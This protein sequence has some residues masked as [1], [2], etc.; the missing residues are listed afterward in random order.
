MIPLVR[1]TWLRLAYRQPS[2]L[3]SKSVWPRQRPLQKQQQQCR[4]CYHR[5]QQ[6][7]D[8]RITTRRRQG[9]PQRIFTTVVLSRDDC[10]H[11]WHR[12]WKRSLTSSTTTK[13]TPTAGDPN[14]KGR[15]R[16][17]ILKQ[18]DYLDQIPLQDVR[19]FCFIAHI[20]HGKSSLSSRILELTGNLGED[21]QTLAWDIIEGRTV[22]T[23]GQKERIEIL[24]TLAVEQQRGITV[25]ASCA[26]MLYP[27]PSAVGPTG[28][29]LVN[30]FDLPGHVD[31][32]Q[33]VSRSLH[34]VQGAVLLLDSAQGIQAQTWSAYDK[35]RNMRHPPQLLVALTKVDLETARPVHVALTVSEWL[36]WDDPDRIIWTS[37]RNRI[38][39]KDLLDAVCSQVP[40]PKPLEDDVSLEQDVANGIL[41]AVVVD[42]WY[43]PGGVH[44]LIQVLSG[45]LREGDRIA[46]VSAGG[47]SDGSGTTTQATPANATSKGA[48]TFVLVQQIGLSLPRFHRTSYLKRGQIGSVLLGLR[49]PRQ[50][51][52]GTVLVLST[53]ANKPLLLPDTIPDITT[54]SRSVLFASVHPQEADG[55]DELS[56][57]VERL[58]LNDS[59]LEVQ[60]TTSSGRGNEDGG[61][62][63]GPGLRVGFQGLLH[64][65]VF[66]QRLRDEFNIDAIVTPPKVPYTIRYLPDK[67]TNRTEEFTKVVEDLVDW[68]EHGEKFHVM[69]PIVFC[70]IIARIDDTGAVLD[71]LTRKRAFDIQ[72]DA[73]D[74]EKWLFTANIPWAEVVTDFHDQL[75]TI[76]AGY[77][78]LDAAT[79]NIGENLVKA[80]LHKVE[81]ILNEEIVEP[82]SFICHKDKMQAEGKIVCQ[83]VRNFVFVGNMI[84]F[85]IFS[86]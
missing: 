11:E 56:N 31:F 65:E 75:K 29:L 41:R 25:K 32:G 79:S 30:M 39:V 16:V 19:N 26:S 8:R 59:G 38:G 61:P 7:Q 83:K 36:Q 24:D 21:A 49:D 81:I 68:P 55:F 72:S 48:P 66:R 51:V 74:E 23:M 63:L 3:S 22:Y 80:D 5:P 46:L 34:F 33:E 12:I 82:L 73:L 60:M 84:V 20:D 4:C 15:P 53:H 86:F 14:S 64:V 76:T 85:A 62:F 1:G 71:L 44:C 70:R 13:T 2:P 18:Q 40:P 57:A 28:T 50:A 67:K 43:E 17:S 58:A 78:S 45:V 9:Q 47:G 37:A 6:P 10:E 69:E 27:H 42:S 77:G 35:A 52:P 54:A